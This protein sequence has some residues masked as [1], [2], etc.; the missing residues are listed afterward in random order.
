MM[1]TKPYSEKTSELIDNEV[2]GLIEE[3]YKRAGEILRKNKDGLTQLAEILLEKEVIFTEDLERIFG[4]RPW[5]TME[6]KEKEIKEEIKGKQKQEFEQY[7][8]EIDNSEV[9]DGSKT[10]NEDKIADN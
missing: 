8:S 6:E 5:K 1:F 7:K 9:A 4:K 2:K 10:E 3:A